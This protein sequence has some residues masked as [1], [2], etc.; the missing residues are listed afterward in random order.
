MRI[1][2]ERVGPAGTAVL[3]LVGLLAVGLAIH[4]AHQPGLGLGGTTAGAAGAI[5]PG[6]SAHPTPT[7]TPA[8]SP[9]GRPTGPRSAPAARPTASS[10]APAST[11]GAA[12]GSPAAGA[13]AVK[14]GPA[15]STSPYAAY[16]FQ[17]YPGAPSSQAQLALAGFRTAVRRQ[18]TALQ[19]TIDILGS[20]QAPVHQ[21]YAAGD[22]IY[23]I[24]ANFGDDTGSTEFNF[25]DDGVVATNPEGRIIE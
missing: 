4:G 25:G 13:P 16:A 11:A 19:L 3:I 18:G 22:R 15:L 8:P 2:P 21:T 23:F 12:A 24:E 20:G 6:G 5:A 7:P 9:A 1:G 14:L 17:I 10:T